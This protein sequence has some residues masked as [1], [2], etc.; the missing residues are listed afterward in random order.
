MLGQIVLG[1][2]IG[3]T[4]YFHTDIVVREKVL[5]PDGTPMMQ[6]V[7]SDQT[8]DPNAIVVTRDVKSTKVNVPFFKNNEFDYARIIGFMGEGSKKYV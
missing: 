6:V 8:A 7:E 3:L 2:I 1:S 4:M 5:Q